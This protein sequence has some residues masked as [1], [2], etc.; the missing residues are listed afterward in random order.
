M[1]PIQEV[2]RNN[3]CVVI[4]HLAPGQGPGGNLSHRCVFYLGDVYRSEDFLSILI[5]SI[6][7]VATLIVSYGTNFG[8]KDLIVTHAP[9]NGL[10]IDLLLRFALQDQNR[11]LRSIARLECV[12]V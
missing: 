6:D 2:G 12:R 11:G 8:H 10:L 9:L 7:L 3:G 1:L 4:E 5:S